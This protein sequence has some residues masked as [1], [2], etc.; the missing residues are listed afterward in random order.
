MLRVGTSGWHYKDWQGLF[1]PHKMTSDHY[2]AYY[3]RTFDTVELNSVFY[4][5]P[6]RETVKEWWRTTPSD[7]LFAYKGSRF[8][9][10]LKKLED[11]REPLRQMFQ[12]AR[13]LKNKLAV[14]LWQ[15]PPFFKKD[16]TRLD[17]FIRQLPKAPRHVFEFREPSWYDSEIFNLLERHAIGLCLHDMKGKE[18]PWVVTSK[19]VYIRFHGPSEQK[20]HGLYRSADLQPW[21]RR[22]QTCLQEKRDVFVY[23]NNDYEGHALVN[24]G[25][26]RARTGL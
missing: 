5:L 6:S 26:L 13:A 7:F 10:H 15:L 24:A 8:I 11:C 20:Y 19:L 18:P 4:R 12:R 17:T 9:T 22:I 25:Q 2:L 16:L 21:V 1:Y 23:F 3:A 14:V